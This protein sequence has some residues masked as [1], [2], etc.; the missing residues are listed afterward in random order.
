MPVSSVCKKHIIQQQDEIK[1]KYQSQDMCS[2]HT[3]IL[4]RRG[5]CRSKWHYL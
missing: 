3:M 5:K 1:D 2:N 4:T